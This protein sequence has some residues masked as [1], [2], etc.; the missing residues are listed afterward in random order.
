TAGGDKN[1]DGIAEITACFKKEDL[2]LLFSGLSGTQSV[3]VTVQGN[4]SG[5]GQFCGNTTLTVKAGGGG[6]RVASI[7]PNPLN[8]SALLT[9]ATSRTGAVKVQLFDMQGR[10]IR[11]L[12]DQPSAAAGHHDVAIDGRDAI[13]NRLAS[14]VY[15]IKIQS[16]EGT[17]AKAI[18]ILK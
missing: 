6:S 3:A 7:S 2:Q 18:T 12:M 9:F 4:L 8:P 11:T 15:Y 14:G 1:G 10:L 16:V 13:G 5:G 17:E